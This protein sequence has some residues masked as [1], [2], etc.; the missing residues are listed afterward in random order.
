[1]SE[2]TLR[3][4]GG[5]PALPTSADVAAC[6]VRLAPSTSPANSQAVLRA[7]I[8]SQVVA[9]AVALQPRFDLPVRGYRPTQSFVEGSAVI[10]LVQ[11]DELV[12]D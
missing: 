9:V 4:S 5:S 2:L 3:D 7:A 8:G 11:V 10:V 6:C 12:E 1:M